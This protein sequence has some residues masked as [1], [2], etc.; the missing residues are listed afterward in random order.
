M[1]NRKGFSLIELIAVI[2]I[3]GLILIIAIPQFTGSLKTFRTDYYK[4]LDGNVLNS[5]KAFFSDNR[6]YLPNKYLDSAIVDVNTLIDEKYLKELKDYNGASCNIKESYVIAIRK[7]K[8]EI[9]YDV[10]I[11][12]LNDNYDNFDEKESC[13][14]AWKEGEGFSEVI[15]DKP[16]P[17][18]IY[19]GTSRSELKKLVVTYPDIRRCL[20]KAGVCEQE[21]MRVSGK[22]E[23]GVNPVYP[24]NLDTVNPDKVGT[25]DIKYKYENYGAYVDGKV[26]VFENLAPT[27]KITKTNQ[28]VTDN[29]HND[30]K[31]VTSDYD[32]KDRENWAQQLNFTFNFSFGEDA[33]PGLYVTK[34]QIFFNNRWEDYCTPNKGT[35]KCT[36]T[37]LREMDET[38][39]FR[40]IDSEGHISAFTE[41]MGLR[42]DRTKPS[43]TISSSG[44]IGDH[45]WYISDVN[46]FFTSKQDNDGTLPY[47]NAHKVNSGIKEFGVTLKE[48]TAKAT[49]TDKN[50]TDETGR[51]WY[52]YVEDRA[53]NIQKC[54]THFKRDATFP[55]CELKVPEPNGELDGD[56]KWHTQRIVKVEF[57][58]VTDS[59]N[60][61]T[62]YSGVEDY[63]LN[64]WN[65]NKKDDEHTTNGA[66]I[67]YVGEVKD[68]AGNKSKCTI[69]FKQDFEAPTC[70]AKV[71]DPTGRLDEGKKWH[72][73][74]TVHAFVKE[75]DTSDNLSGVDDYGLD[76]WDSGIK[77]QP[78]ET[79]TTGKTYTF[80]IKDK[81][82][83]KGTCSVWFKKDSTK[84][85]CGITTSGIKAP[86]NSWYKT[87]NNT[88]TTVTAS[89]VDG[90]QKDSTSGV[91]SY[92]FNKTNWTKTSSTSTSTSD[93]KFTAYI[94]DKAGNEN[95]CEVKY[96]FD[97]AP[98]TC[99]SVSSSDSTTS[100]VTAVVGCNDTGT[101][102]CSSSTFSKTGQTSD[103]SLTI[104]DNAGNT[105]TCSYSIYLQGQ[106]RSATCATHESKAASPCPTKTCYGTWSGWSAGYC[107][108]SNSNTDTREL[109]GCIYTDEDGVCGWPGIYVCSTRTRSK[110]TCY[111]TCADPSFACISW[112]AFSSWSDDDNCSKSET[113][114][115]KV[116]CQDVYR[117]K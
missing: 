55:K 88:A 74:D 105:A 62:L 41:D 18:W 80:Q 113:T 75:E 44:T 30:S 94:K 102:N 99:G 71:E 79:D 29:I 65:S 40:F 47:E 68:N 115:K 69:K 53:N 96:K 35:N 10:C 56:S 54:D 72:V 11:K 26:Y 91:L 45:E 16:E 60:G 7:S 13:S 48:K 86:G 64:K 17:V 85:T 95:T 73:I 49:D 70:T 21:I 43:C 101:S 46:V 12:C 89:F 110:W 67:E 22:G 57:K 97:N 33:K 23:N 28:V 66:S 107:T 52:G 104:S 61:E 31:A 6:I 27:V 112:N 87:N 100:S 76:S 50:D 34:Y 109:S 8:D 2:V 32:P 83:N 14:I 42:I 3:L 98:P 58:T 39:K 25:Y 37:E 15:F 63:G 111:T 81:A 90:S 114:T 108:K 4:S 51:T 9:T 5:G 92:G 19:K 78:H 20:G 103:G 82:G 106:S 84:P 117:A 93:G 59:P 36:K 38:V 77:N 1:K 116:E 24:V